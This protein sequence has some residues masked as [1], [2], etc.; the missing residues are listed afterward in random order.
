MIR[1]KIYIKEST[2]RIR[3]GKIRLLFYPRLFIASAFLVLCVLI[4][5]ILLLTNGIYK[6]NLDELFYILFH[7]S[8]QVVSD[9]VWNIRL[10]MLVT[11]I[12]VGACLGLSGQ[13]FQSLS[14]NALGSPELIGM[15]SGA[16]LGAAFG[17]IVLNSFALK[18][19]LAAV[20][21]CFIAAIL[22][23]LLGGGKSG[24]INR[25]LMV[26]IG[27]SAFWSSLTALLMT[28][29]DVNIS[30]RAQMWLVGTLNAR[31]WEHALIPSIA[32]LFFLPL[33]VY[34]SG[35]LTALELGQD[36]A[37]QH[38]V[39]IRRLTLA[40]AIIGVGLTAAAVAATGPLSFIALTAPHLA[41]AL[42][43]RKALPVL[44]SALSGSLL[45]VLAQFI[46][47]NLPI[48]IQAPVGL[49]TSV[50]GGI[51][52]IFAIIRRTV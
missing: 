25:M 21:G 18:T 12:S 11:G 36:M 6:I 8:D 28:R 16:A 7:P 46:S 51:Y 20:L 24:Q 14:Q 9:I 33:S 52:L 42:G 43:G 38:G 2:I 10:P 15:S 13:L 49:A 26:G 40:I 29:S 44:T 34:Y 22:G 32:L 23:Y 37:I 31:T 1:R 4:F 39:S 35:Y 27:L 47:Q 30:I 5:G 50:L 17:V 41:G 48:N 19:A 45:V 3:I